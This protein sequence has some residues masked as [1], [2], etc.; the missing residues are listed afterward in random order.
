M[1]LRDQGDDREPEPAATARPRVVRAAEAVEGTVE[2][3]GGE[4]CTRIG[5]VQLDDVVPLHG[6]E[7]DRTRPVRQ[8]VVDEIRKRLLDA[9]G[10]GGD[11][12]R[13]W[14][15]IDVLPSLARA[16]CE[17]LRDRSE[18]LVDTDG[19]SAER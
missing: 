6:K 8:R 13:G 12:R 19:L 4:T 10:I 1:R 14:P 18:K 11:K 3:I 16:T 9:R 7:V 17:A 2:K 15:R 5:D